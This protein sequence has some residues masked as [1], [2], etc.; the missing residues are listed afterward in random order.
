MSCHCPYV[1]IFIYSHALTRVSYSLS[2][3]FSLP[4]PQCLPPPPQQL[5]D[6]RG[7]RPHVELGGCLQGAGGPQASL[8]LA[9][10]GPER[11][12]GENCEGGGKV[13]DG[14]VKK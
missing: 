4:S 12:G 11:E 1:I 5:Q 3:P 7:C 13:E 8:D 9:G 2:S 14:N 10:A 6:Q